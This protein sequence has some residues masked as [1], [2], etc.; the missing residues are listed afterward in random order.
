MTVCFQ[1]LVLQVTVSDD[2]TFYSELVLLHSELG[3]AIRIL[4]FDLWPRVL[5]QTAKKLV[6]LGTTQIRVWVSLT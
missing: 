3:V 2:S 4:P 5:K 1:Y 6:S